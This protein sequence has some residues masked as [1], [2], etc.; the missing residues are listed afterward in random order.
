MSVVKQRNVLDSE[1]GQTLI[2]LRCFNLSLLTLGVLGRELV[3]EIEVVAWRLVA[4]VVL[5]FVVAV[6]GCGGGS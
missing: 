1:G 4:V 5:W 3:H 6:S 2:R